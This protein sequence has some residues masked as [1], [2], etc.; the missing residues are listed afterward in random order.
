MER[1][2]DR[3]TITPVALVALHDLERSPGIR[4]KLE[5]AEDVLDPVLGVAE[6][7]G[8]VLAEE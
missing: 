4:E 8:G 3:P 2:W 6:E 5:R 1:F 7:H